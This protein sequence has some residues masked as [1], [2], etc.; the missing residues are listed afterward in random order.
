[1][2]TPQG[3]E[4]ARPGAGDAVETSPQRPKAHFGGPLPLTPHP[5]HPVTSW[6]TEA[7]SQR[8]FSH[9][10]QQIN[11][12]PLTTASWGELG[13]AVTPQNPTEPRPGPARCPPATC[14][15]AVRGHP[16]TGQL[17]ARGTGRHRGG[18]GHPPPVLPVPVPAPA[19]SRPPPRYLRALPGPCPAP[20]PIYR[21]P[22]RE[23]AP[24]A[25]VWTPPG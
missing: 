3:F 6:G 8:P 7:A 22:H 24:G 17:R 13:G 10:E 16:A 5:M 1:M 18:T 2:C 12:K 25:A 15:R 11:V 4:A 19:P 14:H 20:H 9:Q 21:A 23:P